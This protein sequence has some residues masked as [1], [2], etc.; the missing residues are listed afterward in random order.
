MRDRSRG[1]VFRQAVPDDI[2]Q[3][4]IILRQAVDRMLAEGKKQWDYSYPNEAHIRTDIDSGIGYV[5]ES[6]G[7]VVAYGAVTFDGE[8]A[9]TDIDGQWLSDIRYVVVHRMAVLL[10]SQSR[11]FGMSFIEAVEKFALS[12]GVRSIKVDTNYDNTRMLN[13]LNKLGFT[14]C[15]EIHYQKGPRKAFEKLL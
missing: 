4:G 9:Y 5:L 7:E 6:D 12:K 1:L 15:G 11:G 2:P 10:T 3:A 8:P 13:L 14:Y